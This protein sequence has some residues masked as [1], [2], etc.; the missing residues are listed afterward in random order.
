MCKSARCHPSWVLLPQISSPR[1]AVLK[2]RDEFQGTPRT[3][4]YI[5]SVLRLVLTY[6]E[7]RKR[8]FRLPP[9]WI[10][11]A[12]RPKKLKTGEGH[13]PWEEIEID[14]YRKQWVSGAFERVLFEAF[15]N[16]GQ[17]G[18]DVAPMI[19]QQYFRG[20]IAVAQE[21]TKERVWIPASSDLRAADPWLEGHDH[22][23]LF[24]TAT[25]RPL[26]ADYMRHR[27]RDAMRAAGLPTTARYTGCAIPLRRAGSNWGSIGRR[28]RASSGI[29][30]RRWDS[31]IPRSG[32]A[33][34]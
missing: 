24:P 8:T 2:L 20:E 18:G 1:E 4:N 13:R 14:G 31:N 10:N 3:A 7:E 11:P 28:S 9:H 21:K 22:V 34:G 33:L 30:P 15:L 29:A 25:G 19:R 5:V 6:A 26:R 16:T 27:M 17:R 32:V 12:R 23:V